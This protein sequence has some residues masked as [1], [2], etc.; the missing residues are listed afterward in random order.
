M[1]LT[2]N[3]R[4]APISAPIPQIVKSVPVPAPQKGINAV[5]GLISMGPEE[6]IFMY[7]MSPAQYGTRVR[8]G[9]KEWVTNVDLNG[10]RTL[11]PYTGSSSANDRLFAV[12]QSGF[13][14][15]SAT[16]TAPA[17]IL[18]FPVSNATSGY[19]IWTGYTTIAGQFSVYCDEVNGYYLYTEGGTWAKVTALQVT[20][21]DPNLFSGV[22]IF[23]QRLWFVERNS[24]SAWYLPVGSVIGAATEFN[25]GD[26]FKKGGTLEM[27]FNWTVDGGEGVDDYLVAVS[28]G[29]DVVVY[30][31]S[32]PATAT[33]F[34]LHGL[35]FIGPPPVGRRIGGHFGG[36]LCL[37]SSYGL[38]PMSSLVSG[39]LVQA[40]QTYLSRKITP[41]INSEMAATRDTRGWEVKLISKENL[42]IISA[43]KRASFPFTQFPQ[44]TNNQGWSIYRDIPYL[45]GEEWHSNFYIAAANGNVYILQGNRDNVSLN[46][47]TS[48]LI[49]WAVLQSFS[50]VGEP[51]QYHI[52]QYVRP[53][54]IADQAPAY[55]ANIHFDYDLSDTFGTPIPGGSAAGT[56]WDVGIWDVSLWGGEFLTAD[57]PQ[58]ADGIGRAMAIG[59]NGQSGAETILVRHDLMFTSGG[60]L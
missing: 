10:V 60:L 49:S 7:N 45:N 21:V 20:N 32:D 22:T 26:K 41:I 16:G 44:S 18:G 54:F 15:I 38:I 5:D 12:G 50:D 25:F 31:G 42:L 4:P 47:A 13:Y 56:V 3:K 53:V 37:L 2:S 33:D 48:N 35:W 40:E 17:L 39:Q 8:T 6:C 11:I 43:P 46:D 51:G 19:G 23:K 29:G 57:T 9:Y 30:K 58:G 24:G 55:I 52:P 27:L 59:L 36:E 34:E 28:S 14:D 1:L